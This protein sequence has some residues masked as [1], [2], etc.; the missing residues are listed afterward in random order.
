MSWPE[1]GRHV[2]LTGKQARVEGVRALEKLRDVFAKYGMDEDY[3]RNLAH[4][5]EKD[6]AQNQE[7]LT[8]ISTGSE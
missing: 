2:G 5:R 3:L 8:T 7:S 1:V 6:L 4:D